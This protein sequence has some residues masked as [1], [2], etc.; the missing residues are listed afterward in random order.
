MGAWAVWPYLP[1]G[2]VLVSDM[3]NGLFVLDID[4]LVATGIKTTTTTDI[5]FTLFPNPT[6]D[7]IQLTIMNEKGNAEVEIT[8]INGK[9]VFSEQFKI[10]GVLHFWKKEIKDLSKGVYFLH[11]K[12]GN[13]ITTKEFIKE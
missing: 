12:C 11:L 1:S 3:Q 6:I 10:D 5:N 2:N 13:K 8:D 7:K 9:K 4:S